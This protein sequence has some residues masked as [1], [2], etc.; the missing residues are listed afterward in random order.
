MITN[1]H[2]HRPSQLPMQQSEE[3]RLTFFGCQEVR[4]QKRSLSECRSNQQLKNSWRYP[5]RAPKFIQCVG[6]ILTNQRGRKTVKTSG[7]LHQLPMIPNCVASVDDKLGFD[8]I[9]FLHAKPRVPRCSQRH[10]NFSEYYTCVS[11]CMSVCL[12]IYVFLP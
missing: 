6:R 5:A 9:R 8:P 12:C 2:L 7:A 11:V 1:T 10:A 3:E 4:N